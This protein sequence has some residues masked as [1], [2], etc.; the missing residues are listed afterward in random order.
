MGLSFKP[1]IDDM[2][3]SPAVEIV[4][5]F[6]KKHN[7]KIYVV[8]PNIKEL[9]ASFPKNVELIE[10]QE[11]YEANLII[12]LV[13]HSEFRKINWLFQQVSSR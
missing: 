12:F 7:E 10:L 5:S 3:E 6:A 2:R 9:P 13:G 1:D 4:A 11:A 8:E